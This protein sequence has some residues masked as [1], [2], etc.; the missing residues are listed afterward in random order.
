MAKKKAKPA[1]EEADTSEP[2]V[3]ATAQD[4]VVARL[5]DFL[6]SA[7]LSR[8]KSLT[9]G[10]LEYAEDLSKTLMSHA[11]VMCWA[12]GKGVLAVVWFWHWVSATSRVFFPILQ[13]V[14]R[15]YCPR[16]RT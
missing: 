15:I 6:K 16:S 4:Q 14:R 3:P 9:L 7:A 11:N 13:Q 1:K 8:T 2:V 5:D 12:F 10:G